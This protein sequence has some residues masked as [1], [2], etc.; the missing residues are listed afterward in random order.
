MEGAANRYLGIILASNYMF[1][2]PYN[3]SILASIHE[4]AHAAAGT[5]AS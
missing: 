1:K 5:S 4:H 2:R 3:G